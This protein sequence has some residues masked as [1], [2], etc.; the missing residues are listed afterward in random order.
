M[1]IYRPALTACEPWTLRS[2]LRS[3]L[4]ITRIN[5]IRNDQIREELGTK[6]QY[7]IQVPQ[8]S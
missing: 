5:R 4:Q 3:K 7:S 2:K 8:L 1:F 6:S